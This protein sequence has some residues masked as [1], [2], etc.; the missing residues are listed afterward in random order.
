MKHTTLS[1]TAV[2]VVFTAFTA[3]NALAGAG[4]SDSHSETPNIGQPGQAGHIDRTINVEMGEMFFSA[5]DYDLVSGETVRFIVTN[6]GEFLHEF[7]IATEEMHLAH[8]GE[9]MEMMDNGM[10]EVD[11]VNTV[12]MSSMGSSHDDANSLLVEP[13]KTGEV[14]WTFDGNAATEMSCN[15]P[16]HRESGMREILNMI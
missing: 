14:I 13:G 6:T 11:R 16:G 3:T 9:M 15:L 1:A 12:M 10:I 8:A 5:S 4:H 7:S 2:A